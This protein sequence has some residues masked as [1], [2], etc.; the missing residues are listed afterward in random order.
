VGAN[1]DDALV[2]LVR[3][4]VARVPRRTTMARIRL[5]RKL[6]EPM[7]EFDFPVLYARGEEDSIVS[8]LSDAEFFITVP[9]TEG[10]DI[11]GPHL[12]AQARPREVGAALMRL[13]Q[14]TRN[15]L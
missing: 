3:D 5:L 9:G 12:L 13:L 2:D 14:R 1:A 7:Y 8:G 10:V 4:T 15:S 11:E 6:D